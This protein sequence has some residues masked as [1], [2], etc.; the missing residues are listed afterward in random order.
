M[1]INT[2]RVKGT[3]AWT[4]ALL[5]GC[6]T[7]GHVYPFPTGSEPAAELKVNGGP[8]YLLTLN[9]KG[10]YTGKTLVDGNP[11]AAAV[12]VVPGKPLVLSYEA[13][14]LMPFGFT[15][16]QGSRY[17]VTVSDQPSVL[18]TKTFLQALATA[19]TSYRTCTARVIDETDDAHPTP[20][21]AKKKS[22]VH[23]GLTCIKFQ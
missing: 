21:K 1:T 10:C 20:V 18:E 8:V 14:C 19:G 12:K 15:P 4:L 6:T 22:V 3:V 7:V 5:S 23:A 11:D 2:I 9:E 13:S 17:E 16:Q